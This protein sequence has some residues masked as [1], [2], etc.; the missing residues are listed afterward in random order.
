MENGYEYIDA[1]FTQTLT[2]EERK[3]FEAKC[4]DDD[5]FANEVA[6]YVAS[7]KAV[8]QQLLEQ[9]QKIWQASNNTNTTIHIIKPRNNVYVK[10][11]LPHAAAACVI[12]VTSLYFL[13]KPPT[14]QQLAGDYIQKNY[15]Q[16]GINMSTSEDS[17]QTAMVDYNE[18]N[19]NKAMP[20]FEAL[21]KSHPDNSDEKKYA[22]LCYLAIKNYD[23][24]LQQFDILAKTKGLSINEGNFLKAVTLM[25]RD[26]PGDKQHAKEL[27]QQ[28]VG[29]NEE[30]SVE[31]KKWL[32]KF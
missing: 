15:S 16:L 31:A 8:R 29:D 9:K 10:R 30:G 22:G 27:L 14:L 3:S 18:K 4:V 1:Y 23:K 21:E 28:V 5:A 13:I 32:K 26:N 20:L 2:D 19:Y 25:Q 24:A 6:F 12:L 17:L 11:W 7:R